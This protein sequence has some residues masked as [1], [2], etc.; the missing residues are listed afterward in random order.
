MHR[1]I[2]SLQ[3]GQCGNQVGSEFWR[4]L[5]AEH[6]IGLDGALL[7]PDP[8]GDRKDIY[9]TQS[10][11][12]R[13]TP[14][15]ILVDLE[16]RVIQGIQ[17]SDLSGLF[18]PESLFIHP[19]GGGAGN[20][21][22]AGYEIAASV[23]DRLAE[24]VNREAEACDNFAGVTLTHSIAGGTGSGVGSYLLEHIR[25][26]FPKKYIQTY[27]VFPAQGPQGESDVVVQSY[28]GVLAM[29][30][31]ITQADA[32][33]I[34]DNTAIARI[35]GEQLRLAQPSVEQ[36]NSI[37]A[38]VLAATS[39]TMRF[40]DAIYATLPALLSQLIPIE[41]LHFLSLGYTPIA[42]SG[43]H[44]TIAKTSAYE[45]LRRLLLPSQ[46]LVSTPPRTGAYLSMLSVLQGDVSAGDLFDSVERLHPK[47]PAFA[48]WCMRDLQVAVARKSPHV[49]QR[50]RVSGLMIA[51]HTAN[52]TLCRRLCTQFD[53]MYK[54]GAYLNEYRKFAMFA[55][56]LEEF[57]R[58][59]EAAGGLIRAYEEAE[60]A[61]V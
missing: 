30:R 12:G 29:Q 11:S 25:A 6:G 38:R 27:S 51:N 53:K 40:P 46:M 23:A 18:S 49:E 14:R 16:P 15:A 60:T 36:T 57:D 55:D 43:S 24:M 33:F 13:Y 9:F 50:S 19:D 52:A 3:V 20:N 2:I 21:W 44:T 48:P 7:S 47:L 10:D 1:E 39:A 22:A 32:C 26:E 59:R 31:L 56:G 34:V 41:P 5:C 61:E 28:N 42:V 58:C 17:R 8:I 54:H 35:A 37:V 45:V 4:R